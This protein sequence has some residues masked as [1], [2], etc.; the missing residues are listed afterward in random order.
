MGRTKL[1]ALSYT[2]LS[3]VTKCALRQTHWTVLSHRSPPRTGR[4]KQRYR[5]CEIQPPAALTV[6]HSLPLSANV[7]NLIVKA[8]RTCGSVNVRSGS[9]VFVLTKLGTEASLLERPLLPTML[10]WLSRQPAIFISID[11]AAPWHEMTGFLASRPSARNV[12]LTARHSMVPSITSTGTRNSRSR[13]CSSETERASSAST[14]R[15]KLPGHWPSTNS[16]PPCIRCF[17]TYRSSSR[18]RIKSTARADGLYRE[19]HE[20]AH[21]CSFIGQ[22]RSALLISQSGESCR[23]AGGSS[24]SWPSNCSHSRHVGV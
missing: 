15:S 17:S 6:R 12:S 18:R 11:G 20:Q 10:Q 8:T 13:A 23:H 24:T 14:Q 2:R 9:Y 22:P 4:R 5:N 16:S 19:S 1:L 21:V 3:R 7:P